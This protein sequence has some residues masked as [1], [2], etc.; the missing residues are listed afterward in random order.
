MRIRA[1][2]SRGKFD[3]ASSVRSTLWFLTP[4]CCTCHHMPMSNSLISGVTRSLTSSVFRSL[5]SLQE[6]LKSLE[7]LVQLSRHKPGCIA[8]QNSISQGNPSP[9]EVDKLVPI[10]KTSKPI[11]VPVQVS[12]SPRFAGQEQLQVVGRISHEQGE[13][14]AIDGMAITVSEGNQSAFFGESLLRT[15]GLTSAH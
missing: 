4:R 6:Q 9:I 2:G 5:L 3:T 7:E 12:S 15:L 1:N 11:S 14:N 10:T 13:A 8:P